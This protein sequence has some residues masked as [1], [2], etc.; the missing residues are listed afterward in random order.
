MKAP[1]ALEIA[2]LVIILGAVLL[3]YR[4]TF[5]GYFVQGYFLSAGQENP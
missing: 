3:I 1:R 2:A 4:G 5:A